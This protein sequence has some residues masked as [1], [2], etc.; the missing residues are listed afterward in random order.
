MY[1]ALML[2]VL[3]T[4]G[5][6]SREENKEAAE[7]QAKRWAELVAPEGSTIRVGCAPEIGRYSTCTVAV[8]AVNAAQPAVY[9]LLCPGLGAPDFGCQMRV[10]D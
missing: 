5:C 8:W 9:P 4:A 3:A 7:S 1:R 2:I 10:K 6:G